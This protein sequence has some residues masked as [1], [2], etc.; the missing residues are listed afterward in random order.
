M[1][2]PFFQGVLVPLN[3]TNPVRFMTNPCLT[4]PHNKTPIKLPSSNPSPLPPPFRILPPPLT[5][6]PLHNIKSACAISPQQT[7]V[8]SRTCDTGC[9]LNMFTGSTLGLT[10]TCPLSKQR[11]LTSTKNMTGSANFLTT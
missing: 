11:N 8:G 4:N 2:P 7:R 10:N 6:T 5:P 3:M 9:N 1:H